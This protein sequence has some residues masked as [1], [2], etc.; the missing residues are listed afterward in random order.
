M[1]PAL[2]AYPWYTVVSGDDVQ[3]GDILESCPVFFPPS[4]TNLDDPFARSV[5]DWAERDVIVLTQSCDIAN[6]KVHDVLLC[7][8]WRRSEIK[9]GHLATPKGLEEARQGKLHAFHLLAECQVPDFTQELRIADFHYLWSLPLGFIRQRA[10]RSPHLRLLPPYREHLS[11]SF[12]RYF[13]R[14]GLPVDIPSFV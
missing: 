7:V 9:K 2:S 10:A 11:Q 1:T 4:T 14:V 12:A 8:L 6:N 5:F 3:Q 13:M